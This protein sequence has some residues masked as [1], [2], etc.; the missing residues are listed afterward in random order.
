M[1]A[2]V[3][4]IVGSVAMLAT[5]V[6]CGGAE[7]PPARECPACQPAAPAAP[8]ANNQAM[9]EHW[10]HLPVRILFTTSGAELS[11]EN[12]ALLDQA[13]ETLRARDNIQK[14]KIEGHTDTRGGDSENSELSRERAQAVLDYLVSKGVPPR[15]LEAVGHGATQP[16]VVEGAHEENRLQNRRVEFRVLVRRPA[17][18][19]GQPL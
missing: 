16:L 7:C 13:V 11:A 17:S 3:S 19:R 14:V 18:E 5:L 1:N 4:W 10:I 15:M 8:A 12:R 6:G 9:E 2:Q